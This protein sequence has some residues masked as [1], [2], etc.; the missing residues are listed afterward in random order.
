M[1]PEVMEDLPYDQ[2]I[3]VY[4]F[5]IVLTELLTRKM[6]FHDLAPVATYLDIVDLVLDEGAT[7][8]IPE[9]GKSLFNDLIENCLNRDPELRPTFTEIIVFC[10]VFYCTYFSSK[11]GN[12]CLSM[13]LNCSLDMMCLVF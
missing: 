12:T 11:F 3:D 2:K 10:L 4:S 1:A 13:P 8:T 9:W 6:P 7:P 5:G